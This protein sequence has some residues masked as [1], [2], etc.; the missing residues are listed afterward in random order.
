M[1]TPH[2]V[3]SRGPLFPGR[4]SFAAHTLTP[5][6]YPNHLVGVPPR[7]GFCGGETAARWRVMEG[8]E[9]VSMKHSKKYRLMIQE[10]KRAKG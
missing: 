4:E 5:S 2:P 8:L 3:F 1:Y 10:V 9:Q 7:N 6:P